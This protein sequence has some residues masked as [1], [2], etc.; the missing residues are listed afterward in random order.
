MRTALVVVTRNRSEVL[1]A[2][3]RA[4]E[5]QTRPPDAMFVV[6]SGSSDHTLDMLACD[7][8]AAT[9]IKAGDNV[10][11]NAGLSLGMRAAFQA[12]YEG[13]WLLDD[14]TEPPRDSLAELIATLEANPQVSGVGYQGGVIRAGTIRHLKTPEA[15]RAQ[16]ALAEGLYQVDFFLVDGALLTRRVV[17]AVG[18]PP[19]DYFMMIGDIEYPYRMTRA[20]F[21]LG[22]FE[23]DR[24]QRATL[25]GRGDEGGKPAW[26]AY[27]KAR[28]QVRMAITYRSPLLLAG[29]LA[30]VARL[31]FVHARKGEGARAVALLHGTWDG[32]RG[33]MGRTVEPTGP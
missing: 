24:M 19:E 7:F 18:Y 1:A 26:R 9:V 17:E 27:Y 25:G 5:R 8:P 28:N 10:G 21:R 3:L 32:L 12:G 15:V 2:T 29:A 31:G 33:R 4:V 30:R 23:S 16:P 20:G 14:D 13:F 11:V 6:D 22:V